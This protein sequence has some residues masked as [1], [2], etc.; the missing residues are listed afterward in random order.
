MDDGSS[1]STTNMSKTCMSKTYGTVSAERQKEMSDLDFVGGLVDGTL[2][3]N[4]V[5]QTLRYDVSEAEPRPASWRRGGT[6]HR[7]QGTST[8]PWYD[9]VPD[10]SNLTPAAI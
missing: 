4:T 9:D 8:R 6:D 1:I 5:A 2:P 10:F 3:L 7:W